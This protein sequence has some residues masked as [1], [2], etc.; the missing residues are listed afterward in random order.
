MESRI[1]MVFG[2]IRLCLAK[3]FH[4]HVGGRALTLILWWL[5]ASWLSREQKLG[6]MFRFIHVWISEKAT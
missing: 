1:L 2:V 5:G 4:R 6:V 3:P